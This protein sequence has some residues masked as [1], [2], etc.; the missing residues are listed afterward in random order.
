MVKCIKRSDEMTF[1]SKHEYIQHEIKKM[2]KENDMQPG[3]RLPTEHELVAKYEVSRHTV[4][5]ALNKLEHEGYI[6]KEQGSGS[7]VSEPSRKNKP[8]EIGVIT[9][10]ISD[11]I[12]PTIIRGIEKELTDKGYSMILTSTNNNIDLE[13]RAIEM[14]MDRNVDG[15][16]VEPTKS[17]YYNPNIGLYLQLKE[18]GIPLVMINARYEEFETPVVALNDYKA[19]YDSTKY[20]IENGHSQLGGIFKV[21]DRQGKERLKGFIQACY[22]YGI[23]YDSKNVLTFET[24]DLLKVLADKTPDIIRNKSVS[25]FVCYND[26]VAIDL[27]NIIWQEGYSVPEDFSIVSHD[28]SSLS[29]M[30]SVHL[31]GIEHPKSDLGKVAAELLTNYIEGDLKKVE[32]YIFDGKLIEKESVIKI[33]AED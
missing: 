23:E 15:L 28:N 32:P 21:D 13:R 14:M 26:K 18:M 8:K 9:T 24:D 20:L 33:N 2:I 1:R 4:R 11:Y 22:E 6:Y 12:F 25:A 10:Y 7:F 27:L 30:T 31:T 29:S 5:T 19:G 16:I 17:S 3:D